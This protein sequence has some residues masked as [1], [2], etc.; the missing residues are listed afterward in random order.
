MLFSMLHGHRGHSYSRLALRLCQGPWYCCEGQLGEDCWNT[1]HTNLIKLIYIGLSRM[2]VI[3]V[4]RPI[5]KYGI[6]SMVAEEL[7]NWL[8]ANF[9]KDVPLAHMLDADTSVERLDQMVHT[10]H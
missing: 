9:A 10:E 3:D 7:R 5:S 2:V 8:F 4:T 6:D 1:Y